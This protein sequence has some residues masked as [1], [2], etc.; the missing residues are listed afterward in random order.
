MDMM[1]QAIAY[2]S[3]Y[4]FMFGMLLSFAAGFVISAYIKVDISLRD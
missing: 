4:K 3:P 1:H 2:L